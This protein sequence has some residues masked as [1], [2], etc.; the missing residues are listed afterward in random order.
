MRIF[1]LLTLFVASAV[2][3]GANAVAQQTAPKPVMVGMKAMPIT[4]TAG[5]YQLINQVIDLPPGGMVP[6]HVHGGPAV[7]TLVSGALVE[8]DS[9]GSHTV[10]AGQSFYEPAG[11]AHSVVNNGVVT[12]RVS[13]SYLIP[14][15]AKVITI[16]K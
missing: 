1:S 11:Y 13:V 3:L 6:K 7:V 12:A 16:V 14:K 10:K 2:A 4:V 8:T 5:S 9:T 15:G